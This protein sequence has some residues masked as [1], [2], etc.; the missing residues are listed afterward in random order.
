ML[1]HAGLMGE[2]INADAEHLQSQARLFG[3]VAAS[4]EAASLE[5]P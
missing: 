4:L 1:Q 2:Y 5:V 3:A